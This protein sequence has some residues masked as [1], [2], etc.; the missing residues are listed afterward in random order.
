M[1]LKIVIDD[2]YAWLKSYTPKARRRLIEAA[3]DKLSAEEIQHLLSL[4]ASPRQ[5]ENPGLKDEPS[6]EADK[7]EIDLS[8]LEI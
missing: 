6:G 8:E 1:L 7:P 5:V 2:R 3:L 4:P